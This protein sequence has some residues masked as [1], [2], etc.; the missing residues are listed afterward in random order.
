MKTTLYLI[1]HAESD[2]AVRDAKTRPL[3]EKGLRDAKKLPQFFKTVPVTRIF[4][5]PYLRASQTV[6]PLSKDKNLPVITDERAREW[7]GGR[8]FPQ[9]IFESRM[10]EMFEDEKATNGGAESLKALKKRT[11]ALLMHLLT[12]YP[13]ETIV[14]GTHALALTAAIMN[15]DSSIGLEFLMNLLPVTPYI[16]EMIFED[17]ALVSM[18]FINPCYEETAFSREDKI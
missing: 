8:P 13:G 14:I 10:R 12:R 3:T 16:A 1:R 17:F 15:F 4:S 18:R 5:S 2:H 7:M 11:M 9:E 6:L